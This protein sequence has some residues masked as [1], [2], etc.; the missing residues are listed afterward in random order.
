[1][2]ITNHWNK[3]GK[4][5]A[6]S[7]SHCE[8]RF[9]SPVRLSFTRSN[10]LLGLPR[11]SAYSAAAGHYTARAAA[12]DVSERVELGGRQVDFEYSHYQVLPCRGSD[13]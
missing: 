2:M 13:R 4:P 11:R 5:G 7:D 8:S 10:S 1:M 3:P 12:Q 6:K 9:G